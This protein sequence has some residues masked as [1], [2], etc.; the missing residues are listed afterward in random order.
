M[1]S[2]SKSHVGFCDFRPLLAPV[3]GLAAGGEE[4]AANASPL[5]FDPIVVSVSF[6]VYAKGPFCFRSSRGFAFGYMLDVGFAS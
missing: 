1:I 4:P 2:N 3:T 5:L 6:F